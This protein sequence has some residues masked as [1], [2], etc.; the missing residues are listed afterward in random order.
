MLHKALTLAAMAYAALGVELPCHR[1][2]PEPC[3]LWVLYNGE[4]LGPYGSRPGRLLPP[5]S[6][7]RALR[8]LL[9]G[10]EAQVRERIKAL[11]PG[12]TIQAQAMVEDYRRW[13]ARIRAEYL[14]GHYLRVA[15]SAHFACW[16]LPTA[17]HDQLLRY[18]LEGPPVQL[19]LLLPLTP[20][21]R[22]QEKV[23]VYLH[24]PGRSATGQWLPWPEER[25]EV[26]VWFESLVVVV[27]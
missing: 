7:G 24:A 6:L 2:A 12:R 3:P 8:Q 14:T 13:E 27:G 20:C 25:V 16:Q 17:V 23:S 15:H 21:M 5:R 11:P 9:V 1:L 19:V 10:C 4:V 26:G 18:P 22:P